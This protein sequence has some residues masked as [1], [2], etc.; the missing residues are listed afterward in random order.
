M[1]KESLVRPRD[2]FVYARFRNI[3]GLPKSNHSTN[4]TDNPY[5]KAH[6]KG[7]DPSTGRHTFQH[8]DLL[9]RIPMFSGRQ[10][11]LRNI[12]ISHFRDL[13]ILIE[14]HKLVNSHELTAPTTP[15]PST[16]AVG[17][18]STNERQPD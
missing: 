2:A 12:H 15:R 14:K 17:P 8:T 9:P 1:W 16:S 4:E 13:Y 18:I 7:Y 11:N 5:T 6:V 10:K 3:T